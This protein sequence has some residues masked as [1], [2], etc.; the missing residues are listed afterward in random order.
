M[1]SEILI[2]PFIIGMGHSIETDHVLTVGNLVNFQKSNYLNE[3]MRG[4]SWG[5]GHTVSVIVAA[6]VWINLKNSSLISTGF[7]LEILAGFLLV[8]VGIMKVYKFLNQTYP[9]KENRKTDFF[10]IGL[11]HGLAGSG[12][13]AI[14]LTGQKTGIWDQLSFLF[15]FGTGTII[16]MSIIAGLITKFRKLSPGYLNI[17]SCSMALMSIA[18]GINIIINQIS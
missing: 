4:A 17:L 7:S 10:H 11:V 9:T 13:V 8:Y 16:G 5:L 15:L 12:T 14:L 6:I 3:A 1:I 2:A 18:Y